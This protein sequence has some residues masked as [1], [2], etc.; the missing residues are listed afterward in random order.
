MK[1]IIATIS[2]ILALCSC[3]KEFE[4]DIP[5]SGRSLVIHCY[6]SAEDT[7]FVNLFQAHSL[8]SREVSYDK[9]DVEEV[10]LESD[11]NPVKLTQ[12]SPTQWY[13]VGEIKSGSDIRI[14]AKAEGIPAA[15]A[16]SR[17]PASPEIPS[18]T[19]S[20]FKDSDGRYIKYDLDFGLFPDNDI[21]AVALEI[22]SKTEYYENGILTDSNEIRNFV[23]PGFTA[24]N[25]S[26]IGSLEPSRNNLYAFYSKNPLEWRGENDATVFVIH[27]NKVENGKFS[28]S[29][30]FTPDN[31][32][33]YS[34]D[35]TDENGAQT[36]ESVDVLVLTKH[37]YRII[38]YNFTDEAVNYMKARDNQ[39]YSKLNALG[40]YPPNFTYTNIRNGFGIFGGYS[41]VKSGWMENL[42]DN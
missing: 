20:I 25:N 24:E 4:L 34:Y 15:S 39:E 38:F 19:R 26:L 33:S 40:L 7:T 5:G 6:A 42:Q 27:G 2:I 12:L 11:G 10:R 28:I 21:L 1:K 31:S 37:S 13:S 30:S 3:E 14:Y 16:A 8:N 9:L 32:L 35:M 18:I 36:G 17:I 22:A 29:Y 23:T 41:I